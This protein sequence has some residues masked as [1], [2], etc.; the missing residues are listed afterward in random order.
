MRIMWLGIPSEF[1]TGYGVQTGLFTRELRRLGHDVSIASINMGCHAYKNTDGIPTIGAGP[2]SHGGSDFILRHVKEQKPDFVLSMFDT[3][4]VSEDKFARLG[5][6]WVAWQIIDSEPINPYIKPYCEIPELN[7][8]MSRHGQRMMK[9][10]D[11]ASEYV[12]C[13]YDATQYY[14]EPSK[15][16]CRKKLAGAW[17]A[18]IGPDT[19]VV[20]MVAANMS[21]PSRKNFSAAFSGFAKF[22]K[23]HPDSIL[24]CHTENTGTLQNGENL[25]LT[26]ELHGLNPDC[27]VFPDQYQ[28]IYNRYTP[29]YLRTV[30]SAADAYV[31][32]SMGE[33]FTIPLVEAQSCGCPALATNWTACP[34]VLAA[35]YD[36]RSLLNGVRWCR[37]P[38]CEWMIVSGE[39]VQRGLEH[40]FLNRVLET[41]AEIA[42]RSQQMFDRYAIENVSRN[43][44][45]P[46]LKLIEERIPAWTIKTLPAA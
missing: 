42:N 37:V 1:N 40:L 10:A 28:Y 4:I 7:I 11:I 2:R 46:L 6:P 43:Y 20:V 32:T 13:A 30:Y 34:E 29:E 38:G 36:T 41:E 12:P 24:Y 18:P 23:D 17:E 22:H 21:A 5:V 44:L 27:L 25:Q 3:F 8:A 19:F 15:E 14:P 31:C 39:E 9:A 26:A 45:Q 35:P 16:D 33:G